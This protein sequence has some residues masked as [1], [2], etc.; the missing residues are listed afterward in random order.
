MLSYSNSI[1]CTTDNVGNEYILTFKQ[2]SPII[3][4]SGNVAETQTIVVAE[5]VLTNS[6]F[7]ALTELLND[8]LKR[9]NQDK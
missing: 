7:K 4:D 6:S 5:V 9:Q 3:D 8:T 1:S 2:V